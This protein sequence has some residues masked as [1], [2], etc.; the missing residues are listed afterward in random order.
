MQSS[1][2]PGPASAFTTT[3]WSIVLSVKENQ[4]DAEAALEKLCGIYWRP[5][6]A[7]VGR[8]GYSREQ[9]EDLTQEFFARLL[10]RDFLRN[11]L[12]QHGKFRSFLL[13]SLKNFLTN[14]WDKQRAQKRGGSVSFVSFDDMAPGEL[15]NLGI[16]S[17][18]PP[19]RHFE[20]RWAITVLELALSRLRHDFAA[21]KKEEQFDT[22]KGFLIFQQECSY[23]EA[24]EKLGTTEGALK[25]VVHRMRQRFADLL[26]DIV[27]ETVAR[28]ED[29]EEELRFVA[30]ALGSVDS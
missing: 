17:E 24:A 8:L 3:H 30:A 10:R 22:L 26:R 9:A 13:A 15:P 18:L 21:S 29:V 5:L 25:V 2:K 4:A 20:R 16:A 12:P 6:A 7:Y 27:T 19:D 23:L 1:E 14:E 28:A 11:V